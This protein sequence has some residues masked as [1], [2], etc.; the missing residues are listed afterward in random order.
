MYTYTS[1]HN[2]RILSE[3]LLYSSFLLL[4]TGN[5]SFLR[6]ELSVGPLPELM[7]EG[8]GGDLGALA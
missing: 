4:E 8:Q 7:V 5:L 2:K 3:M 1:Y 6:T